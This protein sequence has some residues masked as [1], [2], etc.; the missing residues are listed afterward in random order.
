LL[1]TWLT[2]GNQQQSPRDRECS[3]TNNLT[4]HERINVFGG[5]VL[6]KDVRSMILSLILG[7]GCLSRT[8][9]SK[10]NK[11]YGILAIQHGEKQRDYLEWKIELV[12]KLLNRSM[13]VQNHKKGPALWTTHRRLKA[14]RKF[15]YPKGIKDITKILPFITNP[16]MA[17]AI[18][19]MDDGYVE[20]SID[21][22]YN[23]LYSASFRIFTCSTPVDDQDKV[24]EWFESHF[25][26]TPRIKFQKR[27][28]HHYVKDGEDFP[29]LKFNVEDSLKLWGLMREFVLQFDSMKHKFRYIEAIYQVRVIQRTAK[30]LDLDDIVHT[31][32]NR[33]GITKDK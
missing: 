19:M 8:P 4:N 10:T 2:P 29:F 22:R 25:N 20:P 9:P 17:L 32:G 6:R 15:C 13:T 26:V 14:W 12:N 23:K 21:K 27:G 5:I 11:T 16:T 30:S 28:K 31:F 24:I 3:E 33:D 1:E 7:D 18:W